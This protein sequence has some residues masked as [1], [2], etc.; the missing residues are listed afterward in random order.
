MP[1]FEK[2]NSNFSETR[3]GCVKGGKKAST[4][5]EPGHFARARSDLL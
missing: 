5:G 3:D 2:F 4:R 1:D